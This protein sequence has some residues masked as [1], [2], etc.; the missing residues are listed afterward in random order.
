M[1][2]YFLLHDEATLGGEI[3]PALGAAWRQRRF[4]PCR[5]VCERWLPAARAFAER[6]HTGAAEPLLAC[7]LQ[8]MTFDRSVWRALAGELLW[9]AAAEAPETPT[10]P[11]ALARLLA[12]ERGGSSA[13]SREAFA[14]V[15]QAH[16]GSRDLTFGNICYRPDAAGLNDV[17]D[18][19]RLAAWLAAV[20]PSLWSPQN[21]IGLAE[22]DGEDLEEELEYARQ[23]FAALRESYQRAAAVGR[24]IV[25]ETL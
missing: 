3:A 14:P 15:D 22:T 16:R 1:T 18:T 5:S 2:L 20:D 8:G 17:A 11:Q 24:V 10:A 6:Y 23:C 9:F 4:T 7:V 12:P 13:P 21:L 19:A 25:C